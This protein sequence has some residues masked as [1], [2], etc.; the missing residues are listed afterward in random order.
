MRIESLEKRIA[1]FIVSI[2]QQLLGCSTV[3]IVGRIAKF[4]SEATEKLTIVGQMAVAQLFVGEV[5][6]MPCVVGSICQLVGSLFHWMVAAPVE[7]CLVYKIQCCGVSSGNGYGGV[8][9]MYVSPL[10]GCLQY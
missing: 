1:S 8:G 9:G 2:V 4:E 10:S 7:T 3:F 5:H 6:E